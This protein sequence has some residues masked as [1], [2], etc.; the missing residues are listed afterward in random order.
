[1]ITYLSLGHALGFY[2]EQSR[3]DR[4]E[5]VI[6]YRQNILQGM[7]K[8]SPTNKSQSISKI[9]FFKLYVVNFPQ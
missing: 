7:I 5:Y 9:Y 2:H 4:D 1:M 8:Q 6:I 3:P